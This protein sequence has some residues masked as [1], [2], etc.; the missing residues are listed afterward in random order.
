MVPM[1]KVNTRNICS[2]SRSLSGLEDIIK[3][4]L[5]GILHRLQADMKDRF[6]GNRIL[7]SGTTED[8]RKFA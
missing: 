5:N 2:S 6:D 4:R 7:P 1:K 3:E 8:L